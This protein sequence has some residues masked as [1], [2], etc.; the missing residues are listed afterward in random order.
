MLS[1]LSEEVCIGYLLAFF[2]FFFK[3]KVRVAHVV[4]VAA[5]SKPRGPVGVL[6]LVR[7]SLKKNKR[8]R[9]QSFRGTHT[10]SSSSLEGWHQ[11][12]PTCDVRQRRAILVVVLIKTR[13]KSRCSYYTTRIYTILFQFFRLVP[14]FGYNKQ[15]F[16]GTSISQA[17]TQRRTTVLLT[18]IL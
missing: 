13:E 3:L 4:V 8:T 7:S 11:N 17:L 15:Q 9:D 14:V 5:S 16:T 10:S 1:N 18:K 12:D 2:L 6:C